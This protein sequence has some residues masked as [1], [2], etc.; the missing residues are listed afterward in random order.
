MQRLVFGL[1]AVM[2]ISA[3]SKDSKK[4]PAPVTPPRNADHKPAECPADIVGSYA[5]DGNATNTF[6]IVIVDGILVLKHPKS[7]DAKVD[8]LQV[9]N[10]ETGSANTLICK[11]N[12]IENRY[13]DPNGKTGEAIVSKL[14]DDL[15]VT[16]GNDFVIFRRVGA[17]TSPTETEL[18][19]ET[20]E[21][22]APFDT[23][24]LTLEPGEVVVEQV[25]CSTGYMKEYTYEDTGCSTGKHTFCSKQ[26]YCAG[27]IN[28]ALN[29][30]C[31]PDIRAIKYKANC[32]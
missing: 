3:C 15:K 11:N 14:G 31:A 23:P 19:I 13:T 16:D 24:T 22:S 2:A 18:N 26:D 32:L 6:E 20:P 25:T 8:G 21:V 9:T 12:T 27:L 28:E 29:N 4:N 1:V 10:K 5:E 17:P 30:S 7:G